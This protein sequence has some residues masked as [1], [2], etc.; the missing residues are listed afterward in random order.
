MDRIVS[1]SLREDRRRGWRWMSGGKFV[2]L[3][4]IDTNVDDEECC[5][6][7]VL[8]YMLLYWSST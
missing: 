4:V 6:I 7:R 5:T 3:L 1:V 2:G 8:Y